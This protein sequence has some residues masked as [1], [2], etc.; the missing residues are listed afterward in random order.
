MEAGFNQQS[1]YTLQ[2]LELLSEITS[3]CV[4]NKIDVWLR[5]GWAIDFLLGK[6]TREHSDIDLVSLIQFNSQIEKILTDAGYSSIPVSELQTDYVKGNVD[7]SFVFVIKSDDGMVIA[8]GFPDWQWRS[9]SLQFD[10]L[11]LQGISV[12]VLSPQQLLEE[13]EVYESGTG[14]KPRPKDIE[15]M[16]IL[17]GIIETVQ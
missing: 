5:G 14:R 7:I 9:D 2:Q 1:T 17:R 4:A 6:V 8:N 12:K 15:S 16:K 3:L 11:S 13:K 10:S